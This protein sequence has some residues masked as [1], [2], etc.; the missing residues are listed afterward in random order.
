MKYTNF[1]Y[2]FLQ[3]LKFCC[4]FAALFANGKIHYVIADILKSVY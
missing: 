3:I 4:T 2:L 1:N